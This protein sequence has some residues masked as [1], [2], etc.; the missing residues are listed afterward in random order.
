MLAR[1]SFEMLVLEK[2]IGFGFQALN[3]KGENAFTAKSRDLPSDEEPANV[4]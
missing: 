1:R 2:Q 4:C 3:S